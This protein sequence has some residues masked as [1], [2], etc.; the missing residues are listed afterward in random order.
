MQI[1]Y[2]KYFIALAEELNFRK[3]SHRLFISEQTLSACIKNG[4]LQSWVE[5]D[6]KA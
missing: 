6:L 5:N 2:L 1:N 3:A 4:F